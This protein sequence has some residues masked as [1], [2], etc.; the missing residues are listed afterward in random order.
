[1]RAI[2]V[3][4]KPP[5]GS[6]AGNVLKHGTGAL[7]IDGCR[8]G[9]TSESDKWKPGSGGTVYRRYMD[10][11]GQDYQQGHH[12]PT[13]NTATPNAGG[14]WPANLVLEHKEV[15]KPL[16]LMGIRGNRTDTRPEGDGG[17][18]D[19]SQWRI[20]PTAATRR[21]YADKDGLETVEAW[22]CAEGCPIV[23]LD[24]QSGTSQSAPRAG[25]E[26]EYL[27]PTREGWRF[28]RALGGF[29][30]SGGASR[31]FKQVGGQPYT[32]HD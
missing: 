20:R 14:R 31:F 23:G 15:C 25:G 1:M 3:L 29:T 16:G 17:R 10:G 12:E 32:N 8:L 6:V 24:G 27:D 18:A 7:N 30:D 19:K 22:D 2:L 21:G 28:R 26:G 4:R 9:F 5:E 11:S 13:Q